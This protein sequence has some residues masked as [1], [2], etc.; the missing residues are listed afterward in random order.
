MAERKD[1]RHVTDEQISLEL[2]EKERE[3]IASMH[4]WLDARQLPILTE[5]IL[6]LRLSIERFNRQSSRYSKI[7]IWLTTV[8]TIAVGIQIY[9]LIR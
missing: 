4:Q 7:L 9:L 6:L 5:K 8:M 3:S 2:E 1:L